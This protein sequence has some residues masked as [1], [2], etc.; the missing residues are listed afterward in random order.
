MFVCVM[1]SRFQSLKQQLWIIFVYKI[2]EDNVLFSFAVLFGWFSTLLFITV[3]DK[4]KDTKKKIWLSLS[5]RTE[6]LFFLSFSLSLYLLD[7]IKPRV[8]MCVLIRP[9]WKLTQKL[10]TFSQTTHAGERE[11]K[12]ALRGGCWVRR[13]MPS[14]VRRR[15]RERESKGKVLI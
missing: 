6:S 4:K 1:K 10:V 5:C 9:S 13:S 15:E 7:Y 3:N 14:A 8:C 2:V 12:E 11:E